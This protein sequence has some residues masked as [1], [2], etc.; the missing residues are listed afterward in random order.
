MINGKQSVMFTIS[1]MKVGGG[2]IQLNYSWKSENGINMWKNQLC[3]GS[4]IIE[5]I[6][7][8]KQ[9]YLKPTGG[10]KKKSLTLLKIW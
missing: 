1:D 2:S 4:I 8:K 3:A 6:K 10:G 9:G 5:H 7:K